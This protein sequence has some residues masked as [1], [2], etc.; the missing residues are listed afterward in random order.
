M[1]RVLELGLEHT[2]PW[3]VQK[4]LRSGPRGMDLGMWDKRIKRLC[5]VLKYLSVERPWLADIEG[6]HKIHYYNERAED[7]SMARGVHWF[8]S[9]STDPEELVDNF[10][11]TG[12]CVVDDRP[13]FVKYLRRFFNL[14]IVGKHLET[15]PNAVFLFTAN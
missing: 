5:T 13:S 7:M 3:S 9:R 1:L 14:D 2:V 8:A 4:T 10:L 12:K 15:S 11:R 6:L